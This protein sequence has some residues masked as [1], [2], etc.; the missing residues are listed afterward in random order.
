MSGG[1]S[2][3]G[4]NRGPRYYRF[5][6][7]TS[8]SGGPLWKLTPARMCEMLVGL[9]DVDLGSVDAIRRSRFLVDYDIIYV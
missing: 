9:G 3:P 6:A 5:K 2:P 4:V 7:T 1:R 8:E